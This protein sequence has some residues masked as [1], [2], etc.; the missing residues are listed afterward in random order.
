MH[1]IGETSADVQEVNIHGKTAVFASFRARL[2]PK[3]GQAFRSFFCSF[4]G[5]ASQ[6]AIGN[7]QSGT[8][9]R[10]IPP[11]DYRLS[12]NP[13]SKALSYSARDS[14]NLPSLPQQ[15]HDYFL[16]VVHSASSL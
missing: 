11:L 14:L 8:G 5:E 15:S 9:L 3:G 4:W 12:T 16:D 7:R 1:Q 2:L 13:L 10:A 6:S